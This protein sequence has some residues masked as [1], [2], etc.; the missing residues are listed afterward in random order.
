MVE[1]PSAVLADSANPAKNVE[2]P[3][4]GSTIKLLRQAILIRRVEERLLALFSEGKLNGTVHTCIGQ[5]WIGV[6]LAAALDDGD[7]VFSTHRGHGHY[8]SR[9]G[10]APGLIAELMGKATG[11]CGGVGGSQHLHAENYYS[12]GVQGGLLPVAAGQALAAKCDDTDHIAVA[13]I[14]DGTLGQGVLYET[15][16][17][18]SRWHL[19]LLI[20][21]EHNGYAQ[22]TNAEQTTAGTVQG[23]AEAF[24]AAYRHADTWQWQDLIGHASNAVGFVR[25]ER[26]P[27]VLEVAT[28]RLKAHSKGDDNRSQ[29]EVRSFE[30]KDYLTQ[31]LQQ[32]PTWVGGLVDEVDVEIDQAVSDAEAAPPCTFAPPA[33]YAPRELSWSE[34]SFERERVVEILHNTLRRQMQQNARILIIGED[35]EGPYGGAFKVTRDLSEQFPGRVRNTPISEAAIVGLG[36][37]AALGGYLPIVEIMFGDFLTLTFDQV[38][39]QACKLSVMFGDDVD[40]PLV[41][42]TPMGGKRGY[43]PTHSQSLEKHFL[44]IPN[45]T[46]LALNAR[47]SPAVVYDRL[48]ET[49]RNP[50]LVIENKVLYTRFLHTEKIPGFDVRCSDEPYPT[51]KITPAGE[52]PDVTVACYGG[53]LEDVEEAILAAFDEHEVLCEVVCPTQIN[54]INIAPIADS[55]RQTGRLVT[56][57]E[58][59]RVASWSSEVLAQLAEAGATP[60]AVE[61]VGHDSIIPSDLIRERELLA[62]TASIAA[63]IARVAA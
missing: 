37:G 13:F 30:E 7:M 27:L 21:V 47:L 3:L 16:N 1:R 50:T 52:S 35:I 55:V 42:R 18:A 9:T 62:S 40:V 10:D 28:Y 4:K 8:L 57:E 48:C 5:E 11:T 56:V 46:I 32:R 17:I 63:A 12:S 25:R 38:F 54:P 58:G 39:Q 60:R 14:G 15:L 53:T 29:D 45:L 49:V 20:V 51:V 61:R 59:S 24:Q 36:T 31:L 2:L 6:A 43:G 22:S 41:I 26:K 44:G 19:P 23:R 33:P 34:P